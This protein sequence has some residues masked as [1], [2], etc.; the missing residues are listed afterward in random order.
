MGSQAM[1]PDMD[2]SHGKESVK[3]TAESSIRGAM[4]KDVHHGLGHPGVGQTHNEII[5]NGEH[6]CKHHGSGLEGVGTYRQ[7]RMERRLPDQRGI[8]REGVRGG[9]YGDKGNL[10]AEEIPPQPADRGHHKYQPRAQPTS[11]NRR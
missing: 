5:H 8:D 6:G 1:N 11:N 9:E 2:R 7:D 10:G 3:T 4:S